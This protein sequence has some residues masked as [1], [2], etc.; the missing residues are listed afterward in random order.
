MY[1]LVFVLLHNTDNLWDVTQ[2]FLSVQDNMSILVC[3]FV[4]INL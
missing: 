2:T 1:G 4:I 3:F